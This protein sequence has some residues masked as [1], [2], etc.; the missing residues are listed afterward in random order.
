MLHILVTGGTGT[1]GR[2]VVPSLRDAGCKVRVLSRHSRESG[3]GIEFVTGD[4][5]TSSGIDAAMKGVDII[6]H[7]AGSNSGDEVKTQNLVRAA[8]GVG[9]KHLVYISVVGADRVPVEGFMD[10]AMFGYFA[11]KR[12]SEQIVIDSGLPWTILRATQFHDL[13]FTV[14]QAMAKLPV[15]PTFAGFKYQ[16]VAAEEVADRLVQLTLGEPVGFAPDLGGPRIY[17]MAD[18]MRAYLRARH[19]RRLIIPMWQPG[20]AASAHRA[21]ANLTP[22]HSDGIR[23]WEEFLAERLSVAGDSRS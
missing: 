6:L 11:S 18:L 3:E 4:L 12:A 21:G 9:V 8:S 20:K 23:T 1:L 10:R 22:D 7:C 13:L 14:A 2:N 5:T 17:A 16:P 15:M 19:Q